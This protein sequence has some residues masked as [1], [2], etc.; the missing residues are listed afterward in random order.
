VRAL[1]TGGSGFCG[2]HLVC[3]LKSQSVEIHT[4]GRRPA[5]GGVHHS[6]PDPGD[7]G[8]IAAALD[9]ARPD[10][11][12]H[13]AGVSRAADVATYY[14]VNTLYAAN[15]V[16]AAESVGLGD[17]PILLVGTSAEYGSTADQGPVDESATARPLSHY[18]V[19]KLAQTQMAQTVARQGRP[20]IVARPSNIIG[21]GMPDRSAVQSFIRQ[22]GEIV[23][24]RR[25]PVVEVGNL[26]AIRDFIDVDDVVALYA[27]LVCEPAASGEVINVCTGQG[28]QMGE[29]LSRLI[30]IAGVPIEIRRDP[31]RAKPDDVRSHVGNPT[32]LRRL[33]NPVSLTPLDVTLA[34][35]YRSVVAAP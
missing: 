12:F 6:L 27:R 22:I 13:L 14:R 10:Y 9:T 8:A 33:L 31:A 32:K 28:T 2:R 19:S 4:L 15:L 29:I 34:R 23:K 30:R 35:I 21:P 24:Q 25:E 11:I 5:C 20:V 17:R 18:G 7:L 26:D 1:V 16:Q 3:H